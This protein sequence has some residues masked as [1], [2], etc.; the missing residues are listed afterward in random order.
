MRSTPTALFLLLPLA[1]AAQTDKVDYD[2]GFLAAKTLFA[3]REAKAV[4]EPFKGITTNGEV[5]PGLFP[6]KAT[7]V[8][9]APLVAAATAFIA[10]LTPEQKLH[11]VFGVDSPEWR[12]WCNVDNGIYTR[13]GTS[14]RAM[15]PPQ[16]AAARQLLLA[17]LSTRGMALIDAIRR[18][19]ETLAELNRD[20]LAYGEDLYYFTVMG[21]PSPTKPWG[22]QIDGHHLVI[23]VFVL[24]DQVVMTPTFLGGEPVH[25]TTGKYAGNAVLQEEQNGGLALMQQFSPEQGA[26]ATIAAAKL[27]PDNQA[28]AF[29][30]NAVI[31]Y[32]GLP[33]KTF[34]PAQRDQLVALI[35]LF[36]DHQ[37]EGHARVR[38]DEIVAHLDETWFAWVGGSDSNAVFYYRIHSPVVM[39][40]FDHQVPIGTRMINTPGKVTRD[41]IHVVI[42][43]PNGNDYGKDLLRQ[44]LASQP[45]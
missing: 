15:S 7:G 36:I 3:E 20:R 23:N 29:K 32:A 16:I 9:T 31:P 18:T 8:S 26:K 45:H 13:Q 37:E 27:H 28:E 4:A 35:K 42:R 11:T 12:R 24:G 25:T 22:W 1:L 10:S 39:I 38:M 5:L 34:S 44:H 19:D 43:T 33:V 17:T 2:E 21:L 40:E 6:V 14:L 41:H 30:D